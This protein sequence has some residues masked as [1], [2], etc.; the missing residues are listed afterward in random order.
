[1]D[2]ALC[3]LNFKTYQRASKKLTP[4]ELELKA[5]RGLFIF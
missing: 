4:L 5:L 2:E 1:M 3:S